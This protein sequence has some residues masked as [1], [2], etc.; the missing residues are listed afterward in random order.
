MEQKTETRIEINTEITERHYVE[1]RN[2]L[3]KYSQEIHS[4][5]LF[6]F[7]KD[8]DYIRHTIIINSNRQF[9][10][11]NYKDILYSINA[12]LINDCG[13]EAEFFDLRF[14]GYK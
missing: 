1:I 14:N 3:S 4:I 11:I 7:D 13:L 8:Q 9:F 12:T 6:D 5:K 10:I 2:I